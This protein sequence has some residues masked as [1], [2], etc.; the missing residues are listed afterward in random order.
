MTN[1]ECEHQ[2]VLHKQYIRICTLQPTLDFYFIDSINIM[3]YYPIKDVRLLLCL[4]YTWLKTN[5]V[6]I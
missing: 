2:V 4:A 6:Q 5:M 3:K 1:D